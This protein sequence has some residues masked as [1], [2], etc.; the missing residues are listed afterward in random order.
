[1]DHPGPLVACECEMYEPFGRLIKRMYVMERGS[2]DRDDECLGIRRARTLTLLSIMVHALPVGQRN[3]TVT[4][5]AQCSD[6]QRQ[7]T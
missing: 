3:T 2:T 6:L 1:M 7:E 5:G 4:D